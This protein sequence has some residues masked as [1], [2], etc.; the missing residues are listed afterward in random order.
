MAQTGQE[1]GNSAFSK[2]IVT[3]PS[4]TPSAQ[5]DNRARLRI[6]AK[7]VPNASLDERRLW[8]TA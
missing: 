2:R 4:W 6:L 7:C 8:A 5:S 1:N 3:I